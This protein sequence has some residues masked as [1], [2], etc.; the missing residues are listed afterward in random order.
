M[1]QLIAE[2]SSLTS[3]VHRKPTQAGSVYQKIPTDSNSLFNDEAGSVY[4]HQ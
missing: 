4:H 2:N 1:P 3:N